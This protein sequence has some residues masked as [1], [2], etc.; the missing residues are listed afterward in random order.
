MEAVGS[1]V[2]ERWK[3]RPVP[4]AP[5]K[6][7]VPL[8]AK[9]GAVSHETIWWMHEGNRALRVGDWK[10]VAAGRE[11]AWELYD[12]TTDRSEEKNLAATMP[13]KV[14]ELGAIWQGTMREHAALAA[15]D[16]PPEAKATPKK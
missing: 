14:K 6:S 2:P 12:L 9:D 16:L 4:P 8:F 3:D 10:I 5:G 1:K 13:D 15:K 11:A 7:L